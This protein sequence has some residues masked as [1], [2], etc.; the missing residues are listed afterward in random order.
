M[1]NPKR[2]QLTI[3]GTLVLT[4]FIASQASAAPST[5]T[6]ANTCVL[7]A[8]SGYSASFDVNATPDVGTGDYT[9]VR[10]QDKIFSD[11]NLGGIPSPASAVLSFATIDGVDTHV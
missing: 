3:P 8:A 2:L 7:T 4:A 6:L 5:C 11:F 10:Q 9:C 1:T